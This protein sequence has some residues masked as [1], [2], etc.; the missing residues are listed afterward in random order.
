MSSTILRTG[1]RLILPLTFL[2]AAYMWLKGHNEP[3]GGFIAG[4]IFSVGIL[5]YRMSNGPEAFRR[6]VPVHPR[7]LVFYGLGLALLTAIVP[8][9]LG[10]P[11]LTSHTR[12]LP[13]GFGQEIHFTSALLFDTGVMLVVVGVA[14]GMIQ[15]LSEE[16]NI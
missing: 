7:W 15:R 10:Y 8:M 9:L 2:F 16:L 14:V 12:N 6:L 11:F 4:M 13:L 5:L 3:G 1:N